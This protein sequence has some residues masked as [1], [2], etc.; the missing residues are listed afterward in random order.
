MDTRHGFD[1]YDCGSLCCQTVDLLVEIILLYPTGIDVPV[2][3][4]SDY[5]V[6]DTE[7]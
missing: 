7:C 5:L 6:E 4:Y 2:I 1:Y 3:Y